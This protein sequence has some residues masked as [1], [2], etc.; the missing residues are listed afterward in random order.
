MLAKHFPSPKHLK[1]FCHDVDR[2]PDTCIAW[3]KAPAVPSS[4][5]QA[6][7]FWSEKACPE[8][9]RKRWV[10]LFPPFPLFFSKYAVGVCFQ[11]VCVFWMRESIS[12]LVSVLWLRLGGMKA[13][14][15]QAPEG[16]VQV[17]EQ[18]RGRGKG[19]L[20]HSFLSFIFPFPSCTVQGNVGSIPSVW[21]VCINIISLYELTCCRFSFLLTNCSSPQ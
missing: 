16:Q 3:Q 18:E 1:Y 9:A 19:G 6:M 20:G 14:Q 11:G 12:C 13:E 8:A 21:Y 10:S 15:S 7:G 2:S 4:T 5:S 17:A